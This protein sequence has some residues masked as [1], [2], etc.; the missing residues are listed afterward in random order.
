MMFKIKQTN[1]LFVNFE[2]R[3]KNLAKLE[4]FFFLTHELLIIRQT[5]AT[6]MTL[7]THELL[8]IRQTDATYMTLVTHELLIIRQTDATYMTLVTHEQSV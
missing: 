6:Y 8:I 3:K 2:K 7:V 1:C 5:D 4:F